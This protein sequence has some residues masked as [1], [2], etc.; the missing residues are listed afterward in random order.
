MSSRTPPEFYQD[1]ETFLHTVFAIVEG[2]ESL[3]EVRSILSR[4][5]EQDRSKGL[6]TQLENLLIQLFFDRCRKEFLPHSIERLSE[7]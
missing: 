3:P 4:Y 1:L 6:S 2:S 5:L 7:E